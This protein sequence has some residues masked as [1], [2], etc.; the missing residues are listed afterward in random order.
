MKALLFGPRR[1]FS[2]LIMVRGAQAISY[3]ILFAPIDST[4]SPLEFV[5]SGFDCLGD[6]VLGIRYFGFACLCLFPVGLLFN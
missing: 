6:D 5:S 1:N 4:P 2:L 3:S